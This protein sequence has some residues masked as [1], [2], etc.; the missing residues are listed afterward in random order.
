MGDNVKL[1]YHV[2]LCVGLATAFG[3]Q[4]AVQM[5]NKYTGLSVLDGTERI[6]VVDRSCK[7]KELHALQNQDAIQESHYTKDT[8]GTTYNIAFS[9]DGDTVRIQNGS[10]TIESVWRIDKGRMRTYGL[11][12]FTGGRLVVWPTNTNYEAELTI[13][14]SG[15]PIIRSE[16]GTLIEKESSNK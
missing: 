6:L 13:F 14:G 1:I 11:R 10:N 9:A 2:I 15:F 5:D 8:Q 3:C 16:R 4:S 7:G 12:T